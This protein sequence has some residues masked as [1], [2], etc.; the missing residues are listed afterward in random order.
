R[1]VPKALAPSGAFAN[2]SEVAGRVASSPIPKG[3]SVAPTLLAPK[4][5]PP[6]LAVRIRDGYRAVAVKVDESSGVAGWI[7]PDCRV[8]IVAVIQSD[9]YSGSKAKTV[10]KVILENVEVLAVGQDSGTNGEV[11]ALVSKSVTVAVLPEDVPRLHLA[12]TKGTLRLA[13][14]NL[15]DASSGTFSQTT[16]ND[17]LGVSSVPVAGRKSGSTGLAGSI[18][19]GLFSKQPKPT[20]NKT[21]K[22]HDGALAVKSTLSGAA[23]P[24]RGEAW[25]VEV[26]AGA[27]SEEIWF[28][29]RSKNARRL[30]MKQNTRF[31]GQSPNA[32]FGAWPQAEASAGMP[33]PEPAESSESRELKE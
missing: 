33:D 30:D 3:M 13:M 16:D 27:K 5:T 26:L 23:A 15:Q 11:G 10:S 17:L 19:S 6:G 8:D 4:G 25:R 21:D 18:L 14:R 24:V 32:G 9:S 29:G 12:A 31:S 22:D 7:K 20:D 2:V 1:S 28:D